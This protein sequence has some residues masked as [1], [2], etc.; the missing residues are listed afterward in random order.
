MTTDR[1]LTDDELLVVAGGW[2]VGTLAAMGAA[3]SKPS[4]DFS[5]TKFV[6]IASP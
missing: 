2:S 4:N 6:D 3:A 1:E 5:I